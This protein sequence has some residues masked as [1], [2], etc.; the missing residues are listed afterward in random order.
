MK[1]A[2]IKEPKGI[3]KG[4]RNEENCGKLFHHKTSQFNHIQSIPSARLPLWPP[5]DAFNSNIN[6]NEAKQCSKTM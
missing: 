5:Q 3:G 4:G 1:R 2:T 6:N